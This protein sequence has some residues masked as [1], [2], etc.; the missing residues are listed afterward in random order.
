MIASHDVR[1]RVLRI[2]WSLFFVT[3]VATTRLWGQREAIVQV[4]GRAGLTL[5]VAAGAVA[6]VGA[7]LMARIVW[8]LSGRGVQEDC[9]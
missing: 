9:A 6:I 4:S 1:P 3:V 5:D 2:F 8:R 7:V